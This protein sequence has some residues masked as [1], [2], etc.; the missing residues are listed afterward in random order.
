MNFSSLFGAQKQFA[1]LSVRGNCCQTVCARA[2]A[3]L[4]DYA[5]H[6]QTFAR[7]EWVTKQENMTLRLFYCKYW[8]LWRVHNAEFIF[9]TAGLSLF[10]RTVCFWRQDLCFQWLLSCLLF[11]KAAL[12]YLLYV[13]QRISPKHFWFPFY[14]YMKLYFNLESMRLNSSKQHEK[15]FTI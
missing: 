10:R 5:H 13:I 11:L 14:Y 2:W 4:Q 12:N 3:A 7:T 9:G 6:N 1:R 15:L 8:L